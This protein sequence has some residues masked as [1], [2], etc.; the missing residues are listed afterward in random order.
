M[1][2][3]IGL[4]IRTALMAGS[5]TGPAPSPA[6]KQANTMR[7]RALD[8]AVAHFAAA[9]FNKPALDEIARAASVGTDDVVALFGNEGE[10][11][12]TCDDYV[13]GALVGWAHQ[14]ATLA[15]M[16][17][18]MR[19]YTA[20]PGSYRTK[21]DYLG[22]VVAENAPPAERFFEVLVDESET[23]IRAGIR[24][25]TMR[26]SDDPRALAALIAA[27]VLG[28]V[29]MAP[30]IERTLGLGPLQQQMLLHLAVPALELFT[31]GL[32]TD[33]AYLSLVRQAV[34]LLPPTDNDRP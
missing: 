22:R 26:P 14:K 4:L 28:L 21:I 1:S 16:S 25:G 10:L 7:A 18:V 31:H 2:G 32:Y 17:D 15:G 13:L 23:I 8:T 20:D 27:T 29:T 3:M 11:R 19:S 12:Q 24:D 34:S 9:G 6:K 5:G 33:D 30:H